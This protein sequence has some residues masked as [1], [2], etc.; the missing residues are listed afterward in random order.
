MM[1]SLVAKVPIDPRTILKRCRKRPDSANFHH[2][3]FRNGIIARL[4]SG[5]LFDDSNYIQLMVNVD[6]VPI[7]NSSSLSFWPILASI[8]NSNDATPF[9]VSLHCGR[10]APTDINPFFHR[11]IE[12][13]ID[14]EENGLFFN[15]KNTESKW[16]L[17]PAL[18][19]H[20]S[21]VPQ[22]KVIMEKEG[23]I[24]ASILGVLGRD[25]GFISI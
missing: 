11:F 9:E 18:L 13:A 24:G 5:G 15:Q 1:R 10:G 3:G 22:Q 17:S 4:K 6:D 8:I 16:S 14:L 20:A 7:S 21:F 19:R 25:D 23:A 12:E 2:F